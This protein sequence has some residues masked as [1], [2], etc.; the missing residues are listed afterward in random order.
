MAAWLEAPPDPQARAVRLHSVAVAEKGAQSATY[1][2]LPSEVGG[3][4]G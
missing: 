1:M 3:R 4:A 2:E